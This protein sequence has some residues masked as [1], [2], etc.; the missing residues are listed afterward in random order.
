MDVNY[1]GL[2]V[3]PFGLVICFSPI[4][5]AAICTKPNEDADKPHKD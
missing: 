3:V 5:I 2:I 4:L 1:W